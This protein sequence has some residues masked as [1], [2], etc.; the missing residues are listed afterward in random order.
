MS[1]RKLFV[2]LFVFVALALVTLYGC[3]NIETASPTPTI[4]PILEQT[5][6]SITTNIPTP[7]ITQTPAELVEATPWPTSIP[8]VAPTAVP[9]PEDGDW[10]Q[11]YDFS[12]GPEVLIDNNCVLTSLTDCPG[13]TVRFYLAG[14]QENEVYLNGFDI[15]REVQIWTIR[16]VP[17]FNTLT[18][19]PADRIAVGNITD[20]EVLMRQ[21]S[22]FYREC[23]PDVNN[24]L[25]CDCTDYEEEI[26]V[27]Q[28]AYGYNDSHLYL[29]TIWFVSEYSETMY[30][31]D[32]G[33]Q[34]SIPIESGTVL[35]LPFD[36][37][38]EWD[39]T[40]TPLSPTP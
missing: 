39:I 24:P 31:N 3:T 18:I 16:L 26:T 20:V 37:W 40:T 25:E 23:E 32:F 11:V 22:G 38:L 34:T 7:T 1:A 21:S 8:T 12:G 10:Y 9:Y 29:T 17:G 28:S 19:P 6:T 35:L 15:N 27:Y 30:I 2:V 14:H 4:F 5:P 36:N 13:L 33:T